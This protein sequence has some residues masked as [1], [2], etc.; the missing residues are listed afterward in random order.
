MNRRQHQTADDVLPLTRRG[1]LIGVADAGFA[2][3]F[4]A[5]VGLAATP[6]GAAA[7]GFEPT[8]WYSIDRDGIVTV[9]ITRAEM[10]QHVATA[11]A[12]ILA[13]ELEAT[14]ARSASMPSTRI[15]NGRR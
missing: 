15:R 6:S 1:F 13:D 11:L 3:G 12:R 4:A 2:F 10:G 5:T 9:R 8:I 14:G 7:S